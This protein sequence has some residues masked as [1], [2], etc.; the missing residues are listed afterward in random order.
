MVEQVMLL[1]V[2]T[3]PVALEAPVVRGPRVASEAQEA[4]VVSEAQAG[5]ALLVA[6]EALEAR[7]AWVAW[8]GWLSRHVST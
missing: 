1:G 8:V 2:P 3:A 5:R 4:E 6:R 7:A